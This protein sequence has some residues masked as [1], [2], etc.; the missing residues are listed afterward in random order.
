MFSKGKLELF[1]F[2]WDHYVTSPMRR[3]ATWTPTFRGS[4]DKWPLGSHP[5]KAGST[6]QLLS[7]FLVPPKPTVQS[8][9]FFPPHATDARR[10]RLRRACD[11]RMRCAPC[12]SEVFGAVPSFAQGLGFEMVSGLSKMPPE[13]KTLARCGGRP[14][15]PGVA[16][17]GL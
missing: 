14:G 15:W 1:V 5:K 16:G 8:S 4:H 3:M 13:P 9:P 7:G 17:R 6:A 11:A 10:A 2:S 12:G